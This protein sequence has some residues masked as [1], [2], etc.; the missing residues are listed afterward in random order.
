[1]TSDP[2]QP[3]RERRDALRANAAKLHAP[4]QRRE[5]AAQLRSRLLRMIVDNERRRRTPPSAHQV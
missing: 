1:M 4:P 3:T 5:E 2:E